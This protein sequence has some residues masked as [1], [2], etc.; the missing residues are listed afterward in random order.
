MGVNV[1][2]YINPEILCSQLSDT[3]TTYHTNALLFFESSALPTSNGFLPEQPDNNSGKTACSD[4]GVIVAMSTLD[5]S[6][7]LSSVKLQ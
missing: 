3:S 1:R 7:L 5:V 2:V 4:P 6:C